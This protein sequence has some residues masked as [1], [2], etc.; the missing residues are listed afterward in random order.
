VERR[1]RRNEDP[2]FEALGEIGGVP[3]GA[4]L[5]G[6]AELRDVRASTVRRAVV[7]RNIDSM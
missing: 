6:R 5:R 2:W 1:Q 3:G 4:R 7:D